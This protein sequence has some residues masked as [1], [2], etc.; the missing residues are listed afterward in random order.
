MPPPGHAGFLGTF[1]GD[2]LHLVLEADAVQG[3]SAVQK[4]LRHGVNDVRLGVDAGVAV[5]VVEEEG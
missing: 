2:G 5:I 4:V 1:D 3:D